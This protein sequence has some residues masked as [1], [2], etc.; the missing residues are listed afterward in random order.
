MDNE[1][2]KIN[3]LI[4]AKKIKNIIFLP[5]ELQI[6][7]VKG[8]NNNADDIYLV[9]LKKNH[10]TCKG[11]YYNS[12]HKKKCYHIKATHLANSQYLFEIE[13]LNDDK[14]NKYLGIY[15]NNVMDN[16]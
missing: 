10:C 11:F 1:I 6:W 16:N 2:K 8:S 9:D 13:F 3:D 15:L 7:E 14:L 12:E 5:S 4:F